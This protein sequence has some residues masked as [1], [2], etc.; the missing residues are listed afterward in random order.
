MP[1]PGRCAT[2]ITILDLCQARRVEREQLVDER[3]RDAGPRRL[4]SSRSSWQLYAG[5]A[6]VGGPETR[7]SSSKSNSA[8]GDRDDES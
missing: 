8:R 5:S 3:E 4:S 1:K 2:G 6:V 7:F